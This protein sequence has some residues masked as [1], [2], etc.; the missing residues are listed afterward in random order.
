MH[1]GRVLEGVGDVGGF[2]WRRSVDGRVAVLDRVDRCGGLGVVMFEAPGDAHQGFSGAEE[3]V[4]VGTVADSF[5]FDSI[6]LSDEFQGCG[7]QVGK[8][9]VIQGCV[10][11]IVHY[12]ADIEVHVAEFKG[13][14]ARVGGT[15]VAVFRGSK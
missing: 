15:S 3:R 1:F 5:A 8:T 12:A 6:L 11:S 13:L 2:C 10:G 9:V 7:A 14:R 4:C